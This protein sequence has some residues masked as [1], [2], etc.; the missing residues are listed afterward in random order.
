M[1]L[2]QPMISGCFIC[3]LM[4]LPLLARASEKFWL[5]GYKKTIA[6]EAIRYHS[7]YPDENSALLVRAT[8]GKSFMEWE[9]EPVPKNHRGS[10][11][12]FIWMAGIATGKGAHKFFLYVNDKHYLTF[13]SAQDASQ[14]F[15]KVRGKAGS[16]LS[17]KA[18]MVDQFQELFG[19]MFLKM[20]SSALHPGQPLRLKV[21]GESGSSR[22]WCMVF[23]YELKPK[24]SAQSEQALVRR[25][26]KLYQLVKVEISH[27]ALPCDVVVYADSGEKL[28][29][30]LETG[31]NAIYLPVTVIDKEKKINISIVMNGKPIK[32]E[33]VSLK[34]VER[35][36]IYLLPHSHVDIGYSD[37]QQNVERNH[38]KYFE[39]AI[40]LAQKTSHY[41][42]GAQFKW[43][44]EVLW[45][46][47]SYLKE[48]SPEKRALFIEAVRKGWIGLQAL[49]SNELTGLCHSEELLHLTAYARRLSKQYGLAINSAMITDIPSY[50]WGI[51]PALAQARVKYFSSGPNFIPSLPDGGDRIGFALKKWGDR[52]FYWV[53]PSGQEK[54]LFWMAGKG[55]SWFHGLNMG[56]L[57][58]DKKQFIFDYLRQLAES[59]YPYSMVQVRY[60]VGGDNGPPDPKLSDFVKTWNEEYESPQ[61]VIATSSEMFKEFERRYAEIIPAFRGDFTPYWEDGAASTARQTALNRNSAERLLQAETLWAMLDPESFP[62][63]EFY[64]AWRNVALFD[65][66][67]WG[68]SDSVGNPDSP[69]VKAQWDYKQAF[70]Q[71]GERRSRELMAA[72]LKKGQAE[73]KETSSTALNIYNTNSWKR[74]DLVLVPKELSTI[75]DLVKDENG[76]PVPS[77]RLTSGELAFLAKDIP[78]LGAKR[79]FMEKGNA[80]VKGKARAENENLENDMISISVNP[81][82]G[83]ISHF[84]WKKYQEIE[85]VD[86]SQG[87][88]FNE[89]L[90]VPGKDPKQA[91]SEEKV[92][93][94][95]KEPGPLVASLFIESDAPGAYSFKRELRIVN[96]LD[97]LDLISI[98]DKKKIREKESIHF[99]YPIQVLNGIVRL[100]LG[101]GFIRPEFDQIPGSCKDFFCVQ[102]LV[103]ISNEDY[104]LTWVSLDA[105]LVEIGKMTD[106]R[107][108]NS[109]VRLWLQTFEP[110]Q[111][112]YS[113]V[114]NNYWHTNYKA[115]QEG[116]VIFRYSIWP[117]QG[118]E[119]AAIKR[120]GIEQSQSLLATLSDEN[121]PL[122]KKLFTFE[123]SGV[124]V[125][126]L[127]PSEDKK[128]LIVRLYNASG[129]PEQASLKVENSS[130]ASIFISNIFEELLEK[131]DGPFFLPPFG[132]IALRIE[133]L[134]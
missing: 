131:V 78:P 76:T 102:N 54:V 7:P 75:G 125:T 103:D 30:Y 39:Q 55:Y 20:P 6:G 14:K 59:G 26:G 91:Q 31:Y 80:F 53:S 41:P 58:L 43:N 63:D 61:F 15:W 27:I 111:T 45:A 13:N 93:I 22:D 49:L 128:A 112:I 73:T 107:P 124:L 9:T 121:A 77:Q 52:P 16:M 44:A 101:R 67:T 79:F 37:L 5:Q 133:K 48:A 83:A 110:S 36:E 65:E 89:Y 97:R 129:R 126:S 56:N 94:S 85:F 40:D 3:L 132:I 127:R 38:W 134:K 130:S 66:H 113:Y 21:V 92:K 18:T 47:E 19:Y 74:T 24:I 50:T 99:A 71:E 84:K 28:K 8:D 60:T 90:Y 108:A 105:P 81:A 116:S 114:M 1:S 72:I 2:K 69:D 35:R 34:P 62:T 11:V 82:T 117:H 104:G 42:R 64:E 86:Q 98:I 32:I 57:T 88:G 4:I 95:V 10:F 46:V 96:G 109:G 106:E 70:A 115:D 23:E 100:D 119:T 25:D 33:V 87:L 68:A 120:F 122:L 123:A 29:A 51:I 17:F 118:F 12:E